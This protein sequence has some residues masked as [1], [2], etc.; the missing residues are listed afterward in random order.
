MAWISVISPIPARPVSAHWP[1]APIVKAT[2]FKA[3]VIRKP[4]GKLSGAPVNYVDS[5]GQSELGFAIT[6]LLGFELLRSHSGETL[7]TTL[8]GSQGCVP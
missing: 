6:K 8:F 3:L 7:R 5:H 2:R 1:V 4:S